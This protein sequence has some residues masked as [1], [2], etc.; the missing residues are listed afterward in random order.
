MG[1]PGQ[2]CFI[3]FHEEVG[4]MG[5]HIGQLG[6]LCLLYE[7]KCSI[8]GGVVNLCHFC[9]VFLHFSYIGKGGL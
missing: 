7:T 9:A 6:S 3:F 1:P 8:Y 2:S 5:K 4:N